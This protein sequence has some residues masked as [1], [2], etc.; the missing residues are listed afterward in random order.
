MRVSG[1][2][3]IV[4]EVAVLLSVSALDMSAMSARR[5]RA[6]VTAADFSGDEVPMRT[7]YRKASAGASAFFAQLPRMKR[8]GT[9][10]S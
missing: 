10:I 3:A 6:V 5:R 4:A 7:P 2:A 9:V 8:L 1:S